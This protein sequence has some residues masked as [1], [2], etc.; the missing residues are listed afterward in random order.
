MDHHCAFLGQCVG[1]KNMKYFVNYCAWTGSLQLYGFMKTVYMFVT[2]NRPL[3]QSVHS[4]W[5]FYTFAPWNWPYMFFLSEESGG[6]PWLHTLDVCFFWAFL[7]LGIFCF[8][9]LFLLLDNLKNKRS[10][11]TKLK[12][13]SPTQL[14]WHQ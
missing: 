8:F 12:D 14:P 13:D 2:Q 6:L 4:L 11:V 7:Y 3:Q 10:A 5:T 1:K 9:M